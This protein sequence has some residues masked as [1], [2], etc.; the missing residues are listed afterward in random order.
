MPFYS[1]LVC[2]N[3]FRSILPL[4]SVITSSASNDDQIL[5]NIGL[6]IPFVFLNNLLQK[7]IFYSRE[8]IYLTEAV[9]VRKPEVIKTCLNVK[10]NIF[11]V[12]ILQRFYVQKYCTDIL[13]K[14]LL[15]N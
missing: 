6:T 13:L 2:R 7:A 1:N 11:S 8:A 9:L 12:N 5:V 3:E 14:L 15:L 4:H 10:V